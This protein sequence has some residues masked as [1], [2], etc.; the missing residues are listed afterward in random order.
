MHYKISIIVPVYNVEPYIAKCLE[1]IVHQS[2]KELEIVIIND[3]STDNSLNIIEQYSKNYSFIKVYNKSNG[4]LSDARNYGIKHAN[5]EYLAFVDGDDWIDSKMMEEMY[6]LGIKHNAEI[7][8]C[9][10]EKVNENNNSIELLPQMPQSKEKIFLKEDFSIFGEMSCFACN[11]IFKK[12][13]FEG[14]TFPKNLHFED[15]ATIPRLFLKAKTIAKSDKYF[16]KYFVRTGSITRNYNIKGLDIFEAIK[17][18]KKD[19]NT[20]FYSKWTNVWKKFVILQGFYSFLAYYAY[21]KTPEKSY[22]FSKLK[23][24][25]NQEKIT[26]KDI[27]CY[28]RFA[29]NYLFSLGIKK[30]IYYLIQIIKI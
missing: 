5:G 13:L 6:N 24:L 25:I 1:S 23:K 28:T 17:I 14:I 11:K 22:M 26:K 18:V 9:S 27:I 12:E 21:V 15:I 16:Y 30:K 20:C 8:F 2:L 4:G 7:V 19:F 3:G 10:L 29:K